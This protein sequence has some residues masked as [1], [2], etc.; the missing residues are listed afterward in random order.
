M[1]IPK[2]EVLKDV[3]DWAGV[4]NPPTTNVRFEDLDLTTK[5]E[6][7]ELDAYTRRERRVPPRY[8]PSVSTPSM[9]SLPSSCF[10]V[11]GRRVALASFVARRQ[12]P[13]L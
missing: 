12:P 4:G 5:C 8:A 13:L 6:S 2:T 7:D 9:T 1:T 11:V 3:A 10:R